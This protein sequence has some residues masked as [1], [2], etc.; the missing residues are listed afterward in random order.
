MHPSIMLN[1]IHNY[2]TNKMTTEREITIRLVAA[3]L[4]SDRF[5][6]LEDIDVINRALELA[7]MIMLKTDEPVDEIN[8]FPTKVV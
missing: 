3:M 1:T 5:K 4:Q 7:H 6:H 2:K 8:Y